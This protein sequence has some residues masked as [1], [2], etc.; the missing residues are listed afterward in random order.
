MVSNDS[1]KF[2]LERMIWY[3]NE[4]NRTIEYFGNSKEL[5][6][7]NTIYKHALSMCILQLGELTTLLS[8][9]FKDAHAGA[10]WGDI[11][12]MRNIAAHRYGEFSIDFLWDTV[13]VD[14][15]PLR[16]YCETCIT[17]IENCSV[18]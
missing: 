1:N 3:C 13:K 5:L 12:A 2:V 11:K 18:N 10:P 15:N 9:D 6:L 7:A 16:E 14:I 4:V 17:E 8:Q